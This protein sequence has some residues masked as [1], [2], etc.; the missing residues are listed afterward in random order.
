MS[1]QKYY[2]LIDDDWKYCGA[3]LTKSNSTLN[4]EF[5]FDHNLSDE[6]RF[7]SEDKNTLISIDYIHNGTPPHYETTTKRR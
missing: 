5:N 4:K 7:L 6:L 2:V 3:I 1:R